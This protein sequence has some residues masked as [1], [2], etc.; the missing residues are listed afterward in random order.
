MWEESGSIT[1]G[2]TR[3]RLRRNAEKEM[4]IKERG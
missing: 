1:G 3:R 4:E 2:E